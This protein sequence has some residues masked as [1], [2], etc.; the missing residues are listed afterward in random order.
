MITPMG[1][2][3]SFDGIGIDYEVRGEGAPVVLLHGFAA[4]ARL[5]WEAPGIVDAL[6]SS[7]RQVVTTDARGHGRSDRPHEPEAY[8]GGAMARDVSCLLD[9]LGLAHVDLVGYSMGSTTAMQVSALDKRV[10]SAVLGGVG[11]AMLRPTI[12]RQAIA[13]AL[14]DADARSAAPTARAFRR[15]AD[16]S[17]ADLEALAA[18]Q[19]ARRPPP[20]DLSSLAVPVL[21][22]AGDED[23][24]AGPPEGLALAIPGARAAIIKGNHLSAV[25]DPDFPKLIVAFLDQVE[26][27]RLA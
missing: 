27:G 1:R 7:G 23:A 5:N 24:L 15:F 26:E 4:D 10:R 25:R 12:D 6:L 22:I 9:E 20:P 19:R 16:A 8:A 3:A 17:G 2:F 11:G 21:V 14:V 13:E 18:I